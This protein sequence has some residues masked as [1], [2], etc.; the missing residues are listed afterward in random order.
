MFGTRQA[1]QLLAFFNGTARV[2]E[3]KPQTF[4]YEL[5]TATGAFTQNLVR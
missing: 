1:L 3:C 2:V 4:K 5:N